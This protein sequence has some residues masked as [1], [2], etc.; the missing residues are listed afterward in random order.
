MRQSSDDCDVMKIVE[1]GFEEASSAYSKQYHS[2]ASLHSQTDI[3]KL[4][5][6]LSP[7]SYRGQ[8]NYLVY[9]Q[10]KQLLNV[11]RGNKRG[12]DVTFM[13]ESKSTGK[14]KY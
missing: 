7:E 8:G 2:R 1:Y 9:K 10:T 11:H 5:S 13:E 4:D 12:E 14:S 3:E 6:S